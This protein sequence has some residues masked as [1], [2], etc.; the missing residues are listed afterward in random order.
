MKFLKKSFCVVFSV[1]LCFCSV[2]CKSSS[3]VYSNTENY[4]TKSGELTISPYFAYF[5]D[6]K[7]VKELEEIDPEIA[8]EGVSDDGAFNIYFA[9]CNNSPY[10][11]KINEIKVNYIKNADNYDIVDACEFTMDN[12][13]YLASGQTKIVPCVFEKDFVKLVAKLD[14]LSVKASVVYEGCVVNGA[15]P[16][17]KAD[18]L[19]SSVKE[20]KFTSS[21]GIEGSFSIKNNFLKAKNIGEISFMIY[22]DGDKKITKQPV[23]MQVDSTVESGEM[24]TL[25]FAVLPAN[26]ND[27]IKENK[28]FDSVEIK[29][30]EE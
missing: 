11:R 20:L 3:N 4:Y 23:K 24:I 8:K 2:S 10:D 25:K 1:L 9:L 30:T 21:D 29:I 19:T 6:G 26:V 28:L 16:E 22:A 14:D 15:D 7:E 13:V 17:T 18:T 5:N 27:E 12:E